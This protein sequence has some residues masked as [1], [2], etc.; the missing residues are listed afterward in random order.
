MTKIV[1]SGEALSRLASELV[2]E[3]ESIGSYVKNLGTE[4]D[5]IST[6]WQG[7]DA[8]KYLAKMKDDY[9]YLLEEYNSCVDSYAE[10]LGK[11]FSEYEK[12]DNKYQSTKIEV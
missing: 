12:M 8:T 7:A 2:M 9:S 11:V 4:L 3:K 10:Y 1:V 5:Q 6:S